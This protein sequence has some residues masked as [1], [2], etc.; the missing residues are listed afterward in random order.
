[1]AE[2]ALQAAQAE[3][4]HVT[5][6]TTLGEM[7]ASI[8]HEVNQPL[9]A[10]VTNAEAGLRWL[11]RD[12]PDLKEARTAVGNVVKDAHRAGEV[13]HRIRN[14]S[15]KADPQ[16][17]RLDIN[18]VVEEAVTL[19]QHEALRHGMA[20]RFDLASG[21]PPVRGDRI[22][23]QQVIVNLAVNGMEAMATVDRERMLIVRTQRHQSKGVLVAIEDAGVGIEPENVNRVF[24]AFHTTKPAGLGM[25]LSICRSIIEAHG[26]QLWAS[27]N[28]GPGMTFQFMISAYAQQDCSTVS[29][30]E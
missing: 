6:V 9:A 1:V 19:V 21:L 25:G 18:D 29:L 8:A 14:F 4:A 24:N 20:V 22:Q 5:R 26:G 17:T 7:S 15:K 2:R 30:G 13:I 3:L 23:L 28:T 12:V 16:M 10:I 11:G 27:P